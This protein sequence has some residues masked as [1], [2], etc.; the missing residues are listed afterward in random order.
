MPRHPWLLRRQ[1]SRDRFTRKH[2][3]PMHR[4]ALP[5]PRGPPMQP[6]KLS[7]LPPQAEKQGQVCLQAPAPHSPLHNLTTQRTSPQQQG[8]NSA[9][10]S[11]QSFPT[12][13][14]LS[15]RCWTSNTQC[16]QAQQWHL[17]PSYELPATRTSLPLPLLAGPVQDSPK[18][19]ANKKS[20]SPAPNY[21]VG[22][23]DGSNTPIQRPCP[24]LR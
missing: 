3:C 14:T 24:A 20:I 5:L 10:C 2:L 23:Q 22:S 16:Q 12:T 13:S 21:S 6:Q 9:S 15:R 11:T 1:N 8:L 4:C 17:P 7:A 18:G 19:K